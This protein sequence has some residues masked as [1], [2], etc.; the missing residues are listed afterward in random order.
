MS[1]GGNVSIAHEAGQGSKVKWL[2][3]MSMFLY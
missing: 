3:T 2:L 1:K